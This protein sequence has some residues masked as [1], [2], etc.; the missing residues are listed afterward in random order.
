MALS[1]LL[2]TSKSKVLYDD[3]SEESQKRVDNKN[4]KSLAL[5]KRPL[6]QG[7]VTID[8]AATMLGLEPFSFS[9]VKVNK[10][11][12]FIAKQDYSVKAHRRATFNILVDPYWFHQPLTHYPFFRVATFAMVWI[13]IKGRASG[14]TTLR[15]ID[16]SYVNSSDQVEV[17]VRYPI[18][19]NFAVLGSLA[20]FLALEDKHNL[21]VSVSV[22]DSSVQNCVISRTLWFWG[23][24]RTD[25][26]VSMKT[27][28]TVMFE[29]EPLED[30]AI[31]HL[32]S[33]SNF[34]TNVVQ[35]AVGGAF[36][37]KS[38]PELDT[39]KEFGVVKQPKKI[40]ITKKSKSEVSV[41]M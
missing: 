25:L 35:K 9:D 1:R 19:K 14:I 17:E 41:I 16:K 31:N 21:Q 8:Q 15:I 39:E 33:F 24:E 7:R 36:T 29:F 11:D 20:N 26:P 30:K 4:R 10:Y 28:D 40:P 2:S 27:N 6:N 34:T 37:S 38:F 3:L 32:S 5:S 23:I 13:G 22:D 12:M 18:S